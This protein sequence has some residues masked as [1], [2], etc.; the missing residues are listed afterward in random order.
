MVFFPFFAPV[1]VAVDGVGVAVGVTEA[2]E[3]APA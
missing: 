3:P 1:V 2:A